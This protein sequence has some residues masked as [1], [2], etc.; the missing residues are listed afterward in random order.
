MAFDDEDRNID[1]DRAIG[2]SKATEQKPTTVSHFII[3]RS[4]MMTANDDRV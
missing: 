3:C 1:E 2:D 4:R